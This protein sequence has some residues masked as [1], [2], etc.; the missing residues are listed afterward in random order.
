MNFIKKKTLILTVNFC[1]LLIAIVVYTVY[2][3]AL[4]WLCNIEFVTQYLQYRREPVQFFF[5][6]LCFIQQNLFFF[7][8]NLFYTLKM[9]NFKSVKQYPWVKNIKLY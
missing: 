3:I 1:N 2:Q 8:L 9:I 6:F 7:F 5:N 4:M